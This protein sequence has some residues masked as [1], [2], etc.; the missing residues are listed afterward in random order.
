MTKS[1]DVTVDDQSNVTK[2]T[3]IEERAVITPAKGPSPREAARRNTVQARAA[4]VKARRIAIMRKALADR[5]HKRQV[6]RDEAIAA[7]ATLAGNLEDHII[8]TKVVASD[9]FIPEEYQRIF[10]QARAEGIAMR[11]K[12]SRF[13]APHVNQ[14]P[15][16]TLVA[17][18]GQ[19]RIWAA[20]R[21]FGAD[22][23]VP[24]N[25]THVETTVEEAGDFDAENTE[26]RSLNYNAAFRA[27]IHARDSDS[28]Q[29][30]LLLKEVGMRPLW[31]GETR[32]T[33]ATVTACRT[34]EYMIKQGGASS[35]RAVLSILRDVGGT[36]SDWYR[37][38]I[39][40]G[41][42]QFL[43]R[44]D[45]YLRRDRLVEVLKKQ[46][47]SHALDGLTAEHKNSINSSN[48]AAAC[49]ALHYLYNFRMKVGD[50]LPPYSIE[51]ANR[52]SALVRRFARQWIENH[53]KGSAN[54][55]K[56]A[57]AWAP[58]SQLPSKSRPRDVSPS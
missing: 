3:P 18:D 28:L 2:V 16:G 21:C 27:R 24:V 38:F 26:R 13:Q 33:E 9:I 54:G 19:H 30:L 15:D 36:D 11:F 45:G 12:W 17:V 7:A 8:Q 32:G 50:A 35:A 34:V 47:D 57:G 10:D 22:V 14:R 58:G 23:E 1:L 53:E 40:A 51:S 39:L 31:P 42:W 29:V 41:M 5:Q 55:A 48:G 20:Q 46:A 52:H 6:E 25:L 56:R 44:Y 43:L 49:G 4:D 37:D